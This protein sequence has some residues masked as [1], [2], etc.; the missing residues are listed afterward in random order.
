MTHAQLLDAS[1]IDIWMWA[2]TEIQAEPHQCSG[3][4]AVPGGRAR[5]G[6]PSREVREV[7]PVPQLHLSLCDE[8]EGQAQHG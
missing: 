5:E 3:S 6:L 4:A 7:M 2:L 8:Q 1:A